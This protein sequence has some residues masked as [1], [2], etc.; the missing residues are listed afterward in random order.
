LP[1]IYLHIPFCR[2]ACS[3]CDFHFSTNL[4]RRAELADALRQEARLRKDFFGNDRTIETI[5]FGG[6]TPSVLQVGEIQ[7][8]L[9]DL[10]EM[11]DV[12][13]NAEITLEANPDDLDAQYLRE[14]RAIGINRLSI[15]CQSFA[16]QDLQLMNRSHNARQSVEAVMRAQDAGFDN[17]TI[18]LIYGIP[19]SGMVQWERNVRQAIALKVP[20]I[21]AYSL[22]VEEKTLLHHQVLHSKIALEE[23]EEH[24]AQYMTLGAMLDEAGIAQYELSNFARPGYRSRHN[25][26]YWQGKP[27]LGLGPSAHSYNGIER[28]WNIANNA[29]YLQQINAGTVAVE[30]V[31]VLGHFESLNEYIMTHLRIVEGLDLAYMQAEWQFDPFHAEPELLEMAISRGWMVHEDGHLRLSRMGF[32][33][34]D[35]IIEQLFQVPEDAD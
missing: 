6:G 7:Q 35:A 9:G 26:S 29:K 22:T 5:Y 13:G 4:A 8:I 31:E 21:S 10:R 17:L 11:F 20:H 2:K 33:M 25:G 12:E 28:S 23:D 15:G 16:D 14:L 18:D 24:I 32:M 1:G 3:Y 19:G 27:Y 34:S 30:N